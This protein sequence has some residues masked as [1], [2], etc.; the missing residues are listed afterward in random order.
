MQ[1]IVA[2]VIS[3]SEAQKFDRKASQVGNPKSK[4]FLLDLLVHIIQYI[5]RYT[6]ASLV[7]PIK[8]NKSQETHFGKL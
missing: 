7:K 8:K 5:I 4:K 2:C 6:I 1:H 3:V